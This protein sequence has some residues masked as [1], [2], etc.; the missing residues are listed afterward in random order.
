[1]NARYDDEED[2]DETG[3]E[4]RK[5]RYTRLKIA[6]ALFLV[7]FVLLWRRIVIPVDAGQAGVLF[8]R[9]FGGVVL[10]H[11]YGEGLHIIAPWDSMTIYDMRIQE[12]PI[13]YTVLTASGL[14]IKLRL[15]LRFHPEHDTL[16]Y[17]HDTIGPGYVQKVVIPVVQYG[18][19]TVVGAYSIDEVYANKDDM[20]GHIEQMSATM[21]AEKYITLDGIVFKDLKLPKEIRQAI[22][23]KERQRQL[24]EA[25]QFR[26]PIARQE[27]LR[28]QLE[29][30]GWQNY[31]RIVGSSLDN[32]IMT[33]R[34]LET[35]RDLATSHNAKMIVIGSG[36][37]GLPVMLSPQFDAFSR[38]PEERANRAAR[39][40]MDQL[41]LDRKTTNFDARLRGVLEK[42]S[43]PPNPGLPATSTPRVIPAQPEPAPPVV[44]HTDPGGSTSPS[45]ARP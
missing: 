45:P 21:L 23:Y 13:D 28:M 36:Q 38:K 22:E 2:E 1:M 7:A 44:P 39:G 32:R 3:Y 16:A 17:L 8:R 20:L 18:V 37:N 6:F 19:R 25:Y 24:L 12:V 11:V 42:E 31:N 27:A 26:L 33:W 34:A 41:D 40:P 35:T 4:E 30:L 15:S 14:S 9:F 29:A 43:L 10:N 5:F